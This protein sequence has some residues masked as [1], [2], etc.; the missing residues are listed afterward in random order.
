M[1]EA[2]RFSAQKIRMEHAEARVE[3]AEAR[4]EQA[5]TRTEQAKARTEQA[6]AR[7][8]Q[9]ET[10]AEQAET[11][12]EQAKTRAELAET[13]TEQAEIQTEQAKTS[14]QLATHHDVSTSSTSTPPQAVPTEVN[15]THAGSL[16]QL[17]GRQ[18]EI[19]KLI[20]QGQNT[21]ESA[22]LLKVSPKT[23]EYHRKKLMA[24]LNI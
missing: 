10:R 6:E 4:P 13:R 14:L 7:T 17:T 8:E 15:I 24:C 23:I 22:E 20:A 5:E 18:K 9:A 21:K 3:Q 11:R 12:T 16:N 2:A 19:L 1:T